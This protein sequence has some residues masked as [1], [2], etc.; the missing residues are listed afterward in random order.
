M[1]KALAVLAV[2]AACASAQSNVDRPPLAGSANWVGDLRYVP[3]PDDQGVEGYTRYLTFPQTAAREWESLGTS[4]TIEFWAMWFRPVS[5]DDGSWDL[6]LSPFYNETRFLPLVTRHPGGMVNNEWSHFHVQISRTRRGGV[7]NAWAGCGCPDTTPGAVDGNGEQVNLNECG[8]GYLLYSDHP[9]M[10]GGQWWFP[11]EEWHHFAFTFDGDGTAQDNAKSRMAHMYIDGQLR[12]SN[13]WNDGD[14]N[15]HRRNACEGRPLMWAL[16]HGISDE[17][18]LGYLDNQDSPT[19]VGPGG[20]PLGEFEVYG[21]NG[22]MDEVR[23]WR[24]VRTSR[25]IMRSYDL[26]YTASDVDNNPMLLLNVNFNQGPTT[27]GRVPNVGA[28]SDVEGTIVSQSTLGGTAPADNFLWNVSVTL[29]N[30]W[31]TIDDRQLVVAKRPETAGNSVDMYMMTNRFHLRGWDGNPQCDVSRPPSSPPCNTNDPDVDQGPWEGFQLRVTEFSA[32]ILAEMRSTPPRFILRR[33]PSGAVID[34]ETKD[35]QLVHHDEMVEVEAFCVDIQC[36]N[37]RDSDE[38]FRDWGIRYVAHAD[39]DTP[40]ET[41][42]ATLYLTIEGDC[43]G[44]FDA[45]GVCQGRN[46]TC[47]CVVYHN[48]RNVRMAYVLLVHMVDFLIDKVAA[49][50]EVMD[51]TMDVIQASNFNPAAV[52]TEL[53]DQVEDM[54]VFYSGCLADYCAAVTQFEKVLQKFGP[55]HSTFRREVADASVAEHVEGFLAA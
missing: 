21:F 23:L 35:V 42:V 51:E 31:L 29:D 6:N 48:F 33:W 8:F 49:T 22:A 52:S 25:E 19:R 20:L 24:Y 10:L 39:Q 9:D 5:S 26:A 37:F 43:D 13:Q 41:P 16:D 44:E 55:Q 54:M 32:R 28:A 14:N 17:V 15:P 11:P 46:E 38:E 53:A 3:N 50:T 2:T 1:L 30:D 7:I 12:L 47:Q 34:D 18:R 4:F 36:S 27:D 45:C 40:S